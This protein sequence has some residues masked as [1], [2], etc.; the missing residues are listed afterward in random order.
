MSRTNVLI[1]CMVALVLLSLPLFV[2]AEERGEQQPAKIN[3]PLVGS[4]EIYMPNAVGASHWVF[5]FRPDG[6]Y[7]LHAPVVGHAGTFDVPSPG[8]WSLQSRTSNYV[9]GGTFELTDP[10]TLLL[11]GRFGP[12]QWKRVT[13]PRMLPDAPL[14]G[15]RLP[16][17]LRPIVAFETAIARR[18][19][20]TDAIPVVLDTKQENYGSFY[21]EIDL[22]SPSTHSGRL[23][24]RH[25]YDRTTKDFPSVN[26]GERALPTA[27]MDVLDAVAAAH[28]AGMKGPLARAS[29]H[30]WKRAGPVWQIF[31]ASTGNQPGLYQVSAINGAIIKGDFTGYVAHYNAQWNAAIKGLQQ[32][33]ERSMPKSPTSRAYGP[34][35]FMMPGTCKAAGGTYHDSGGGWCGS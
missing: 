5:E 16:V 7:T 17:G 15:Q 6:T 35:Y 9:D 10:N 19:W 30:D 33:I 29:L 18:E 26:W 20:H 11:Q 8:R 25:T 14:A 21:V 32:L 3:S 27:F 12:G 13:Y 34:N 23:V 31:P 24:T 22:Y 28:A 2:L 1:V 4:W